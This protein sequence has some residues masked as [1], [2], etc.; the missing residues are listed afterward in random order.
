[1][2]LFAYG[3][4]WTEGQ[5]A[6]LTKEESINNREERK[7]FRNSKS[8]PKVLSSLLE[9]EHQNQSLTGANNNHIF[10]TAI[11]DIKSGLVNSGDLIIIMW[12]SSLRDNVSFFPPNEWHTWGNNYLKEEHSTKWFLQQNLTKN[13]IYNDFLINFKEFYVNELYNQEY[14][15]IVNQNYILF[16]QKLCEH[17]Q[18][19]YFFCDAF[20]KMIDNVKP[21]NDKT[22]HINKKSYWNFSKKTFK[23]FLMDTNNSKVWETPQYNILNVPEMHPSEFG[24]KLIAEH[25]FEYLNQN[26][27]DIIRYTDNKKI[28]I[29]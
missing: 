25:I 5:G 7:Y 14:Y 8:W 1:M 13:H 6:N 26:K 9:C 2:R 4:S 11:T 19:N 3:D 28:K 22:N 10:N 16:I 21:Q 23:N 17:Y 18:I 20:D 15:N 27:N 24:Y 29:L 12:S